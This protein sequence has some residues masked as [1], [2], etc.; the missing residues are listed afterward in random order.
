MAHRST[1]RISIAI[2]ACLGVA[3]ASAFCLSTPA[4]GQGTPVTA[5]GSP[6]NAKPTSL[7][8]IQRTVASI[9]KE[10]STPEGEEAVVKRLSKQ[11]G[12]SQDSLRAQHAAWG[13]GYGE[14]A[15]V[16]GFA[17]SSKKPGVTP[18][19]VV[20][21]RNGGMAWEAIGAELGVKV[22]AVA[23]RMNKHVAKP[24]PKSK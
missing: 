11:L 6:V 21:M 16:Y 7:Q 14:V 9:N 20:E 13:L 3:I 1:P 5:A 17:K 8:R 10:A 18:N 4:L 24:K 19:Q 2:R 23:S 12:T 22:D 15:M